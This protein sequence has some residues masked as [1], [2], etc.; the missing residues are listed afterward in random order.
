VLRVPEKLDRESVDSGIRF[1]RRG[2]AGAQ[3]R[4]RRGGGDKDG[5]GC[6]NQIY[7]KNAKEE[8]DVHHKLKHPNIIKLL[9]YYY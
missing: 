9:N 5:S 8:I 2:E 6:V 3:Y 1:V 4:E 7:N